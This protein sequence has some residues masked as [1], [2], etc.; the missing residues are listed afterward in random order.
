MRGRP[1]ILRKRNWDGQVG[2]GQTMKKVKKIKPFLVWLPLYNIALIN[3][4]KIDTFPV[5]I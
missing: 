4:S 3:Y 1:L 5:Q 2:G